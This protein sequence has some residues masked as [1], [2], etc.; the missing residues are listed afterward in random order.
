MKCTNRRRGLCISLILAVCLPLLSGCGQKAYAFPYDAEYGVSS[1][2][3][4]STVNASRAVPF[5]EE[6]CIAVGDVTEGTDVD[7]SGAGSAILCDVNNAEIIYARNVHEQMQ[8][9]SLTKIMTALVALKHGSL[10]QVLTATNSVNISESGAQL[11]GLK[12]GDTMTLAQALHVLLIYSANDAAV[13][14]AEGIGGSVEE[15]VELMNEEALALG[16]TNTHFENPHGLTQD[17][18]YSTAYDLYLIFNEAIKYETFREI[19]HMTAYSTTY[20]TADGA[21]KELNIKTTNQYFKGNY[22]PPDN[23]TVVGGKT[24]TTNAAGHCLILLSRDTAG[25]PYISV[26][27]RATA[28]DVLYP[29]MTDLLSEIGK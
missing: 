15:F 25:A 8:P 22:T 9:A 27:L 16:A 14:I 1:F 20:Y 6:L 13:L 19:I 23:V 12:P 10:D 7:T 21:P 29:E 26:I 2:Q 18:H 11:C 24:G 28:L 5:A 17:N 3:I 4:V